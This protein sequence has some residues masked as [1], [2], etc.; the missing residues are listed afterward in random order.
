MESMSAPTVDAIR[1]ELEK[2]MDPEIRRPITELG[3]VRSV[4]VDGGNVGVRKH[5]ST[6]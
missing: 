1:S 4:E 3:M 6:G 2:V 5:I